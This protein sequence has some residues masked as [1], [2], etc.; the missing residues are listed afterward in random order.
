MQ[1]ITPREAREIQERLR[2]RVLRRGALA[3]RLVAGV[4]VSE[5]DGPAR[6]AIVVTRDL[7]PVEE[8]TAEL[9]VEFPY[10]PGLLSFRELP[11]LLDRTGRLAC[12]RAR[13]FLE[14]FQGA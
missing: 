12:R 11:P 10:V 4:D 3:P 8:V 9:P 5:K 13:E 6:A 14:R 1:V 2:G 7:E